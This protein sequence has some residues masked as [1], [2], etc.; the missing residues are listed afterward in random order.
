MFFC[1]KNLIISVALVLSLVVA[2][3]AA[4]LCACLESSQKASH[5]CCEKMK[6]H[7]APAMADA[8]KSIS[9]NETPHSKC[10][11][12]LEKRENSPTKISGKKFA[13]KDALVL[14]SQVLPQFFIAQAKAGQ[15]LFTAQNFPE[16]TSLNQTSAR[17]PPCL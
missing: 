1:L 11:C 17:A 6:M 5:D 15:P 13:D 7:C 12:S 16:N 14:A 2:S 10:E 4:P 8:Q 9:S 3:L